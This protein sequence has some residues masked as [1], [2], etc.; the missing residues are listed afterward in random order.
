[1]T[2][3]TERSFSVANEDSWTDN[4]TMESDPT[5]PRSASGIETIYYPAGFGGGNAPAQSWANKSWNYRTLYLSVWMKI[6]SNW[7]GHPT[8]ANKVVHLFISGSNHVVLNL[9]GSGSGM[10]QIGILLQGIVNDGTGTTAANWLPNLGPTGEI[11][12][13]KWYHVEVVGVGNTAGAANGTVDWWLDGVKIGSHSGI[14]YVSGAGMWE[15]MNWSPTWG[16]GGSVV[17]S[18]MSMSFDHF[19]MSGK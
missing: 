3:I 14:Q 6:S 11:V 8:G 9:W 4:G 17:S 16:G 19:R 10:M 12:R 15:G 7:Q 1:M 2:V 18:T 5:A 13:G